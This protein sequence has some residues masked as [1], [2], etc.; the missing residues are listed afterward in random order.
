M[1]RETNAPSAIEPT[2]RAGDVRAEVEHG[3][4]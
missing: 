3:S 4:K 1:P 2:D